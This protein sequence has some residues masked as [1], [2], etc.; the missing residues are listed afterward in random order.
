MG[1][2][3]FFAH[4]SSRSNIKKN[5]DWYRNLHPDKRAGM[6]FYVWLTRGINLAEITGN[7][8]LFIPVYY[9]SKGAEAV[10][11]DVI[12]VY[13]SH[14]NMSFYNAAYHHLY[15][16]LVVSYPDEGYG[17]LVREMWNAMLTDYTDLNEL[18]A[19]IS[20]LLEEPDIQRLVQNN[21]VAFEALV[22]SA[23]S[24]MPHFMVPGHPLSVKLLEE[25]KIA[26]SLLG[27]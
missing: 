22:A 25:E 14:G 23:S 5:I 27:N 3:G 17:S 24:V 10:L 4:K 20:P 2:F 9:Y 16:N 7:T 6:I 15:T 18:A 21:D 26:K 19:E 1:I 13:K 11:T 12:S 8:N